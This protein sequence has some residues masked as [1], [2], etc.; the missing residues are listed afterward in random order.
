MNKPIY[1]ER[2]I[3]GVR[4]ILG[5]SW[6]VADRDAWIMD[7]YKYQ[8]VYKN[9]GYS[10]NLEFILGLRNNMPILDENT[11]SQYLDLNDDEVV[12][13]EELR[14]SII[15]FDRKD[16]ILAFQPSLYV[17]FIKRQLYS[18]Y[19]ENIPFEKYVPD[20]WESKI[21]NFMELVPREHWYWDVNG[22]NLINEIFK[23]ETAEFRQ[24][25]NNG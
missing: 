10:I 20:G 22:V 16:T 4:T 8:N 15:N 12:S 25:E 17:D 18:S 7:I 21:S 1:A 23:Q 14:S 2:I 24:G 13:T 9:I 11:Y 5:F 3:V 6:H 19:P